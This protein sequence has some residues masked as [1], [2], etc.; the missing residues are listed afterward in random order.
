[1][2]DASTSEVR[3]KGV[4]DTVERVGN[5]LPDPVFIF[6][7]II[8]ILMGLSVVGSSAGWQAVNPVTGEL[9]KA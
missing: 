1:M 2:S 5:A 8:V 4:L 7:G 6:I 9:L 3:R